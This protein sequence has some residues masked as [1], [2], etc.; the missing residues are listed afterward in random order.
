MKKTFYGENLC[1]SSKK[2]LLVKTHD[3]GAGKITKRACRSKGV[4][5]VSLNKAVYIL[6]NP[7]NTLVADFN[8]NKAGKTK[9]A[10]LKLFSTE[11]MFS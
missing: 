7:F 2:M 9:V 6:R 8:Y 5:R 11:S 4:R 1:P 10:P 3:M